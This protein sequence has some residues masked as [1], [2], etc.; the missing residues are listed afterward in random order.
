MDAREIARQLYREARQFV[1]STHDAA[2]LNEDVRRV[3]SAL[4]DCLLDMKLA[5]MD[6]NRRQLRFT[7]DKANALF[8]LLRAT[9]DDFTE[10]PPDEELQ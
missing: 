1:E 4:E 9:L 7:I 5:L 10:P 3:R 6:N 2:V 8:Q